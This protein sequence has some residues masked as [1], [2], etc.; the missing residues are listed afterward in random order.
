[1]ALRQKKT[2]METKAMEMEMEMAETDS[3]DNCSGPFTNHSHDGHER[4]DRTGGI[5]LIVKVP[6]G[7]S[8]ELH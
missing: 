1:M 4:S 6:K 2:R 8:V 3:S 5:P 7:Q